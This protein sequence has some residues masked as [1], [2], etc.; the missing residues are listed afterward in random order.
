MATT[1]CKRTIE[2][3]AEWAD[4]KVYETVGWGIGVNVDMLFA[5]AGGMSIKSDEQKFGD[6]VVQKYKDDNRSHIPDWN[7][8]VLYKFGGGF[9]D[10]GLI[11]TLYSEIIEYLKNPK[12]YKPGKQLPGGAVTLVQVLKKKTY[13]EFD[14]KNVEN[15][16]I[17]LGATYKH[18]TASGGKTKN[19]N[20]IVVCYGLSTTPAG[21]ALVETVTKMID[22]KVSHPKFEAP[23]NSLIDPEFNTYAP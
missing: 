14:P 13:D 6:G 21:I 1:V 17:A 7:K 16:G 20:V 5:T 12:G 18:F 15:V 22:K 23:S 3:S 4:K 11:K 19:N 2:K 8:P 9:I 10:D